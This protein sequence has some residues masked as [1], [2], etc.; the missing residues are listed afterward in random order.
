MAAMVQCFCITY[1]RITPKYDKFIDLCPYKS[2]HFECIVTLN[3]SQ[4][5]VI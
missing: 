4:P 1:F 5:G 2:A 3:I